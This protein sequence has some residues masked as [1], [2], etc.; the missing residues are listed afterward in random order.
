MFGATSAGNENNAL[1][2]DLNDDEYCHW[3]PQNHKNGHRPRSN[4]ED[5]LP[6]SLKEAI[7][8]FI[9]A[10]VIRHFRGQGRKHSSMLIHVTRF[11]SVQKEVVRQVK[12]YIKYLNTRFKR[13]IDTEQIIK[14]FKLQ[15]LNNFG[16]KIKIIQSEFPDI[17]SYPENTWE[18]IEQLLPSILSDIHVKEINGSAKDALEYI[19]N[20]ATGLK[21]IAVGGTSSPEDLR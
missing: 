2:R 10:C 20:E 14:K 15:W 5:D 4:G 7:I 21:V 11:T 16:P 3:M 18:E 1:L 9:L 8:D 19:E 12:D 13:N 17:I 6:D